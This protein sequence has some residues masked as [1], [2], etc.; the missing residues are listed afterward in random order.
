ME[1]SK[2]E[3]WS[4]EPFPFPEDLPYPGI[5]SRSPALQTDCLPS[6]PGKPKTFLVTYKIEI[7]FLLLFMEIEFCLVIWGFGIAAIWNVIEKGGEI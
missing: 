6:P 2:Q 4:G 7:G 1:F 5:E 3:H